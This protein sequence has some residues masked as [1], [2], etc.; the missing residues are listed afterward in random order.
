MGRAHHL[1]KQFVTLETTVTGRKFLN[2]SQALLLGE[3][4]AV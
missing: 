3:A 1:N 4:G 2:L